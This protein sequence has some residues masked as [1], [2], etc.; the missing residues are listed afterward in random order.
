MVQ[1]VFAD[2]SISAAG[3][4]VCVVTTDAVD[5]ITV[6]SSHFNHCL[7]LFIGIEQWPISC[8]NKN[9]NITL[10]ATPV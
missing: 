3:V 1:T 10:A 5:G 8:N 9:G 6:R 7:I 2:G 4:D